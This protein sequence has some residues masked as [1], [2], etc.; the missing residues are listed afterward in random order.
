MHRLALLPLA[1]LLV[2]PVLAQSDAPSDRLAALMAPYAGDDVP[3]VLI[4]I[5]RGGELA[6]AHA[7]GMANLQ[8]AVPM[9]R[10][11]RTNIGSTAKQFTGY[12]LAL[13][14]ER[15]ALSLDDDVRDHLP[16]LPDLGET[17]TLRHLLTH[18]SGY[19]EF[20][21][22][23]AVGGWRLDAGDAIARE[24]IFRV[25]QR[26]PTLQ[27]APG[28]EWNYNNTGYA[29]LAE[30]VARV[31]EEPFPDWMA[32][33]VFGPL[34]ME[35]TV[36]RAHPWQVIPNSAQG[37]VPAEHGFRDGPDIGAAM[38]AGGVY[39][40]LDDLARWTAHLLAG[41]A[42]DLIEQMTTP[43]VLTTGEATQYG[44]GLFIDEEAGQR[45]IQHGGG[46]LAHRAAF[47]VYPDL[48][49]ALFVLTNHGGFDSSRIV[50][51]RAL[52]LGD[53]FDEQPTAATPS[54][55]EPVAFEPEAF[56]V[57]AGRYE[58]EAAPGFILTFWRDGDRLMTQATGQQAFEIT[59]VS[60]STFALSV[61]DA[62]MTFHRDGAGR[63]T[64][65]TLHQ[66]GNHP[67]RRLA[68]DTAAP[69]LSAFEGRYFSDEFEAVYT[70]SEDEGGLVF[71]H[72]RL[73]PVRVEPGEGDRFTGAFPLLEVV[74]ERDETDRVV[75][76]TASSGRARGMRF[77]RME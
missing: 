66:N 47:E 21:N 25:V 11:T 24:E 77:E 51:V 34:G 32:A 12:A 37:Y 7:F 38:G 64:G 19:R 22:A 62:Q 29:L 58:L 40:T 59:A 33:N 31:T 6:E 20:L 42:P 39:T 5:V 69:D 48:D 74:F 35:D 15:G 46:D 14:A 52:L 2:A 1:F 61:V 28:A 45:R 49:A 70:V 3:G 76:F 56:D 36:V 53:P 26:Q 44:L 73:G 41:D 75:A 9:D 57:F 71:T 60:D 13:L 18:T 16:E 27:N 8:H 4:G 30:V 68:D 65:L 54:P 55:S 67:A 63:V 10:A 23:L 43:F 72:R 17:V 50:Q